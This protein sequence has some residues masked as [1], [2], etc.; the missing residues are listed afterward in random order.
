[1]E[2]KMPNTD[3]TVVPIR[4]SARAGVLQV[5]DGFPYLWTRVSPTLYHIIV[6]P[7]NLP[8]AEYTEI[9]REQF[10]ANRLLTCLV[11]SPDQCTYFYPDGRVDESDV[12]PR[13]GVLLCGRLAPGREF[14][15]TPELVARRRRIEAMMEETQRRGG[16]LLGDLTA[17][18]RPATEEEL[19]RLSG[20]HDPG[21]PL[22]LE[23]C[24]VCH[25]YRG[26]HLGSTPKTADKVY[27]VHCLCENHN[28][29]AKCGRALGRYRLN[30]NFCAD[31][32]NGWRHAPGFEGLAHQCPKQSRITKLL[33]LM[34][35]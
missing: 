6:L 28:R 26:E 29:C 27:R 20:E 13:G 23:R 4:E 1:M 18:A 25:Y 24:G 17:G 16:F 19:H 33:R 10:Q 14:E 22:G 9:A 5:F 35:T 15:D 31:W 32:P 21:I 7:Q 12:I 34:R 3:L 11:L 2:L 8:P 30:A